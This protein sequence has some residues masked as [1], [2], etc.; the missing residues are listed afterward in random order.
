[1]LVNYL[2]QV[3]SLCGL[4]VKVHCTNMMLWTKSLMKKSFFVKLENAAEV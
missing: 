3:N 4:V 2:T 1:M